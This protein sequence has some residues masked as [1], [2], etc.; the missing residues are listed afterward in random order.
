M[1]E[2]LIR[3][4]LIIALMALAMAFLLWDF[5]SS[6]SR[7]NSPKRPRKSNPPGN[8]SQA[9]STTPVSNP[10]NVGAGPVFDDPSHVDTTNLDFEFPASDEAMPGR[11]TPHMSPDDEPKLVEVE[12]YADA[13]LYLDDIVQEE[14]I[15]LSKEQV[16]FPGEELGS[17]PVLAALDD[18]DAIGGDTVNIPMLS[19]QDMLEPGASEDMKIEMQELAVETPAHVE[20]ETEAKP[21]APPI[22]KE[23]APEP[24]AEPIAEEAAPEPAAEAV[25]EEAAPELVAEPAA[26]E[27]AR[28]PSPK[29]KSSQPAKPKV[30][31]LP[32]KGERI[33]VS[34]FVPREVNPK[35][36]ILLDVW[37]YKM[38]D[39][40]LVCTRAA[41]N[42]RLTNP[43]PNS[44]L[45][46]EHAALLS[47]SIDIPH[48]KVVDP[49]DS[50][51]WEGRPANASF[52]VEI[53]SES[54][55]GA[56]PGTASIM[57][58]GLLISRIGFLITVSATTA[59]GY[60]DGTV[61]RNWV[62]SAFASYSIAA[63]SV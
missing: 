29:A 12:T 51:L 8:Q 17:D 32:P 46:I 2:E 53:P 37:A 59:A 9:A 19:E 63:S 58:D 14:E 44:D 6:R 55:Q 45:A 4:P 54:V 47:V 30:K 61:E 40:P 7:K 41:K 23:A 18:G 22:V 11:Q 1:F 36:A 31:P 28:E 16:L 42:K 13:N 56:Y 24:A 33:D 38:K 35:T 10:A 15:D 25:A 26:K 21:V 62:S 43:S 5:F 57:V 52:I 20:P 39:Y 60:V 3:N 48:C 27:P 49:A 50:I 34:V